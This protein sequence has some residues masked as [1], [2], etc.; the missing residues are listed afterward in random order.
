MDRPIVWSEV[1]FYLSIWTLFGGAAGTVAYLGATRRRLIAAVPLMFSAFIPF[2]TTFTMFLRTVS[3]RTAFDQNEELLTI[4]LTLVPL[5][6][7]PV[8]G[9]L[10]KQRVWA[11][12]INRTFSLLVGVPVLLSIT[13]FLISKV[14]DGAELMLRRHYDH[15]VSVGDWHKAETRLHECATS[16]NSRVGKA[17][18]EL[19]YSNGDRRLYV[20]TATYQE[21]ESTDVPGL[22]SIKTAFANPYGYA[23]GKAKGDKRSYAYGIEPTPKGVIW[24]DPWGFVSKGMGRPPPSAKTCETATLAYLT[25]YN[26]MMLTL[27]PIKRSIDISP[28]P[29]LPWLSRD[30][31]SPGLYDNMYEGTSRSEYL[32]TLTLPIQLLAFDKQGLRQADLD[33][34]RQR[35]IAQTL[36]LQRSKVLRFDRNGD[37]SVTRSEIVNAPLGRGGAEISDALLAEYDHNND[38]IVSPSEIDT[39]AT[40]EV[41]ARPYPMSAIRLLLSREPSHDGVLS[42]AELTAQGKGAFALI[43]TNGDGSISKEEIVGNGKTLLAQS[44]ADN[45]AADRLFGARCGIPTA[46]SKA[47]I[48]GVF[49]NTSKE[50]SLYRFKGEYYKRHVIN[51]HIKRGIKPLYL[52]FSSHDSMNWKIDGA[53]DR[54]QRVVA[55]SDQTLGQ[56]RP[57]LNV[58]GLSKN[59]VSIVRAQCFRSLDSAWDDND[60]G[61]ATAAIQRSLGR[62]P[63]KLIVTYEL[64]NF[65]LD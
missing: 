43:D 36:Q 3:D 21:S 63:E 40:T 13:C 5:L 56:Y 42:L 51:I 9:L 38:Q 37:G 62:N 14:L 4:A 24:T 64:Q 28:D 65:E 22:A 53:V 46:P 31:K 60:A 10:L 32:K 57:S 59:K 48:S 45:K 25:A 17:D 58:E 8:Q 26:S 34:E 19:N 49:I 15:N 23:E 35:F 39:S 33:R 41:D 54:I 27:G 61:V 52:V 16:L 47:V 11:F 44:T 2:V 18:A 7:F 1:A 12:W 20:I 50:T 29:V 30:I 6:V 55:T